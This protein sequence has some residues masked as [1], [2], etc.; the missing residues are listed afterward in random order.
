MTPKQ[1]LS[2]A[3]FFEYLQFKCGTF[4]DNQYSACPKNARA[5]VRVTNKQQSP[6]NVLINAHD[7]GFLLI[8]DFR[9]CDESHKKYGQNK[10]G[11]YFGNS[12]NAC[13]VFTSLPP[14]MWLNAKLKFFT[15]MTDGANNSLITSEAEGRASP[16]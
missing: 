10:C 4:L 7:A 1:R 9:A 11:N 13:I 8:H 16:R 15:L 14:K 6:Y 2:P 3:Y 5:I 12:V